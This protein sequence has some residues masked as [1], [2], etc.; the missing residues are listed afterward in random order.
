MTANRYLI[1]TA[2]DFGMGPATTEGILDLAGAN[3]ITAT[4]LLVNSPY[5]ADAVQAWRRAGRPVELGWHPCLTM[6]RPVLPARVVPSLVDSTGRFHALGAFLRRTFARR[7]IRAEVD[8]ELRAQ[9]ERFV[10]LVGAPP[11][12][13]NAHHHVQIFS[14]VAESLL[15]LLE[16][17]RP[18]PY[19]RMVQEPSRTL[20]RIPGARIKRLLL[21]YW[22]R[23]LTGLQRRIGLP[24]N[25][26]LAGVTHPR[27]L[28]DARFFTRWL[29]ETPGQ[30]VELT[31]HPGYLDPTLLGRDAEADAGYLERRPREWELLRHPS[32]REAVLD[33]GFE[34]IAPSALRGE[35]GGVTKAA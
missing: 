11:I 17:A 21:H 14:P 32:F 5:A 10:D 15:A 26:S 20:T 4:V 9:R 3:L 8:A 23:R 30:F 27:A 28:N 2:D 33:A 22:G 6:D 1:V 7:I 19:L 13:V 18:R 24:G 35:V 12:V 34:L 16:D 25:D 31:C 29:K